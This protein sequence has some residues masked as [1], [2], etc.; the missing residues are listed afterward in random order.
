M[1]EI[2]ISMTISVYLKILYYDIGLF[3]ISIQHYI[4]KQIWRWGC[5][6]NLPTHQNRPNSVGGIGLQKDFDSGLGWIL[7]IKFKTRQT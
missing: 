3:C 2:T 4:H 5:A 6:A 1:G 7:V